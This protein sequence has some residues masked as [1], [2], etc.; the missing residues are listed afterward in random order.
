MTTRTIYH[1]EAAD[2]VIRSALLECLLPSNR[3]DECEDCGVL[4]DR[5]ESR[6]RLVPTPWGTDMLSVCEDCEFK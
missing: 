5:W 6:T 1:G 3:I 4:M 2:I